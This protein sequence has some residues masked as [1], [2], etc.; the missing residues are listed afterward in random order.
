MR[1]SNNI[2]QYGHVVILYGGNSPER[3][4]SLISGK[5]VYETLQSAG[6]KCSLVDSANNVVEQ[7]QHL[8]PDRAFIALHGTNGEDGV[9][10]G[11]LKI[12]GIPFTGSD[13]QSSALAIDK[14]RSKLVWKSIGLPTPDFHLVKSI[15]DIPAVYP[16]PCFVKATCQ[17]STLGTYPVSLRS[18]LKLAIKKALSFGKEVI[19][20]RWIK[21]REFSVS[22][23]NGSALPVVR[24]VPASGFYDYEAKYKVDTTRYLI[25]CG[26]NKKSEQE[27][28]YL[29]EK[30]F[31]A[32][33]C[34][35]WGRVDFM[36]D[37]EGGF[38]L[39]E[40]NTVPGM[41]AHSIVPQA[42]K[43]AGI[44]LRSLVLKILDSAFFDKA[45][46]VKGITNDERV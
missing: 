40:A 36:E 30:A 15:D 16:F 39:I 44:N 31:N 7:L 17:G 37:S 34:K 9:I 5:C 27:M 29:A 18:E 33:G 26:L 22:F 24:I 3:E 8:K 42:A 12:M 13:V 45:I 41:T 1:I 28:Q 6:V 20:E 35:C 43:S 23:L 11:L 10:Q 32:L 4:V 25:P 19:I 2:S 38:W 21:G 14:Y 46:P